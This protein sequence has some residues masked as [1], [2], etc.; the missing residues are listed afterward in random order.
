MKD[1]ILIDGVWYVRE[2]S[3]TKLKEIQNDDVTHSQ[4]K[5]WE[6]SNWCFE[7]TV[8][9]RD[10]AETLDDHYPGPM[11]IITDKRPSERKDWVIH[12]D[13]DNPSWVLG[14]YEGDPEFMPDAH[15]MMDDNGI[16]EFRL[17]IGYLIKIG[18]LI[19]K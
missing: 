3:E 1:R 19:K 15:E 13:I 5:T 2:T 11:V 18:W 17:F 14:V 7:A 9:M 6:T 8:I 10:N 16:E 4:R 12:D